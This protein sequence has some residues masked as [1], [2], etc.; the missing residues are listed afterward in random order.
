M[1]C[2]WPPAAAPSVPAFS[3]EAV[4]G[5]D[6][7]SGSLGPDIFGCMGTEGIDGREIFKLGSCDVAVAWQRGWQ[8]S[9]GEGAHNE[10]ATAALS[11][12]CRGQVCLHSRLQN[13]CRCYARRVT[14]IASILMFVWFTRTT[15]LS[16]HACL[17]NLCTA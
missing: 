3:G 9:G 6:G 16:L 5:M 4:E 17:K 13:Q 11:Q 1:E 10:A 7:F 12:V 2:L 14:L 8:R 15:A